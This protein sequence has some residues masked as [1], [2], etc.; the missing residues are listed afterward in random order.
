MPA[1][2][3]NLFVTVD[4]TTGAS[5]FLILSGAVQ[6]PSSTADSNP[7]TIDPSDSRIYPSDT[8]TLDSAASPSSTPATV[9]LSLEQLLQQSPEVMQAALT[10]LQAMPPEKR[11]TLELQAFIPQLVDALRNSGVVVT[12]T[13]SSQAPTVQE[14]AAKLAA[15]QA[16]AN[17][18]GSN[19]TPSQSEAAQ[20]A[21]ERKK[22]LEQA[23]AQATAT[24][25][26]SN[27]AAAASNAAP[28][29]TA[30]GSTASPGPATTATPATF[31]DLA[32][33][34]GLA[35]LLGHAAGND[36]SP[37]ASLTR[38]EFATTVQ[39]GMDLSLSTPPGTP[40]FADT[41]ST[42]TLNDAVIAA[43]V[44]AAAKSGVA[45][46][47]V[48]SNTPGAPSFTPLPDR[49]SSE[50]LAQLAAALVAGHGTGP[51]SLPTLPNGVLPDWD[52]DDVQQ[53]LL[54]QHMQSPGFQALLAGSPS[55]PDIPPVEERPPVE[56]FPPYV[57]DRP[58]DK[59][60]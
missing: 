25:P 17:V 27:M 23:K 6:S 44:M 42:S 37:N 49:P 22:K 43:G 38:A 31:Q 5:K 9:S 52:A 60:L 30:A 33:A 18:P 7:T 40:T 20:K 47:Q 53:L 15:Q 4:P 21:E 13:A 26:P 48:P 35:E 58:V 51:L 54:N 19:A 57:E 14:A 50:S 55:T 46:S 41:P 1:H 34:P 56:E 8:L 10:A 11:S 16:A 39:R 29:P 12:E 36:A 28:Q 3:T 59:P 32:K 24:Q 2:A 45:T